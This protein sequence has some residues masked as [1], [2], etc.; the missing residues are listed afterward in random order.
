MQANNEYQEK[1]KGGHS[2]D[3][4]M[5]SLSWDIEEGRSIHREMLTCMEHCVPGLFGHHNTA[6]KLT[7]I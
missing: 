1:L 5:F 7:S 4:T 3:Q 2:T 6:S